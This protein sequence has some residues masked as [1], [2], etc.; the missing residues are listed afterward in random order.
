MASAALS[1]QAPTELLDWLRTLG[2]NDAALAKI[3]SGGFQQPASLTVAQANY[4]ALHDELHMSDEQ[5]CCT[6]RLMRETR[7]R[8]GSVC[9]SHRLFQLHVL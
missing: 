9:H 2:L 7:A 1:V 4:A 3:Q 5:V 6:S 8:L